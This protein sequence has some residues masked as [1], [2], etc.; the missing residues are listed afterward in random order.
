[1]TPGT[2]TLMASALALGLA[3]TA[4]HAQDQHILQMEQDADGGASYESF[5][6]TF[7]AAGL[8]DAYD[9][10]GDG[11]LTREELNRGVFA[12]YDRDRDE[13][14]NTEETETLI[15]AWDAPVKAGLHG[16]EQDSGDPGAN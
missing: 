16:T 10:D 7:D 8:F 12:S 5:G 13:R 14:L 15:D 6:R 3:A 11:M 4:A 9:A 2:R 1:M